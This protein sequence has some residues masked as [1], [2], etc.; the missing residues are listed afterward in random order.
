MG[1]P[2]K[3]QIVNYPLVGITFIG[4]I[5]FYSEY[6]LD[7]F[8]LNSDNSKLR[9]RSSFTRMPLFHVDFSKPK[10]MGVYNKRTF[11]F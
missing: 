2:C 10:K 9:I 3:P 6:P 5:L 8:T 1:F 7:A 4:D 11:F